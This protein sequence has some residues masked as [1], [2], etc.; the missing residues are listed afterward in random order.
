LSVCI[1][2]IDNDVLKKLITFEL[3][4]WT[5]D[6]FNCSYQQVNI[7]ETA[8]YKFEGDWRKL[9]KGKS[10]RTE[11]KLI[12]YEEVVALAKTLPQISEV[13][14]AIEIFEQLS[15]FE[16]IDP[17]EAIL[18]SHAIALL[19]EDEDAQIFTGDKRFLTALAQV[20]LPEINAY[21][22]HRMWCLE[23]LVLKNID[24]YGFEWVRE[25]IVPVRDCDRAIKV[26]FGSGDQSSSCN[27]IPT[28]KQYIEDVRASTGS[29]LS[30]YPISAK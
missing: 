18:T 22:K 26:V 7:L 12:K 5:L 2:C 27:A 14:V 4:D 9:K 28:L 10:R 25:Q 1:Y 3:F 17:G 11:D 19:K 29:L 21:L 6:L 15:S 20:D 13:S 24:C 23:Q 8:Q 30:L 16:N